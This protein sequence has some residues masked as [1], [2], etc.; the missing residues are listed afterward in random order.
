MEVDSMSTEIFIGLGI[1]LCVVFIFAFVFI[2]WKSSRHSKEPTANSIWVDETPE[3]DTDRPGLQPAFYAQPDVADV[4]TSVKAAESQENAEEAI[5]EDDYES[6]PKDVPGRKKTRSLGFVAKVAIVLVGA[7]LLSSV[8]TL[9]GGWSVNAP[10]PHQILTS[11][12]SPTP[13]PKAKIK[14]NS[15]ARAKAKARAKARRAHRK[16]RRLLRQ[17]NR[18]Q[19]N[20]LIIPL[21]MLV[22]GVPV[23]FVC[24][25]VLI[26]HEIKQKRRAQS[27][28]VY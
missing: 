26:N 23:V 2:A 11:E 27:M 25:G 28:P 21:W 14:P 7:W 16:Y 12:A 13:P 10:K 9:A 6:E 18:Q 22:L 3:P 15:S 5:P 4:V 24:L 17:F 20:R 19:R 1:L 8:V